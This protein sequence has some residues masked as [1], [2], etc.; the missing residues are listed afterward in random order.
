ME[1]EGIVQLY[2]DRN[3]NAIEESVKKYGA[4]CSAIARNILSAPEDIEE[5]VN[6]T[7]LHAWNAMPPHRPKRLS[8]FLGKITRNLSFDRYKSQHRA[9]RGG[10]TM[11][12]VLDELAECVS[13][14]ET[15]EQQIQ[16][17]ELKEDINR[18]LLSLSED[19]RYQFLLRY[20]YASSISEIAKRFHKTEDQV[21]VSLF[22]IRQQ[23]KAYLKEKGY[24]L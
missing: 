15:P 3:E 17:K 18:F 16:E 2:F 20:W 23:L 9:K 19:Q 22:R 1:D 21:S 14:G 11:E 12:L 10:N 4:Y 6:D 24:S 8:T 7:W 5:C 13:N